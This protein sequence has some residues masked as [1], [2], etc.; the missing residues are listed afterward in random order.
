MLHSFSCCTLF[1][2]HFGQVA[3]FPW[4]TFCNIV[5]S[6]CNFVALH[7]L[8][9]ALFSCRPRLMLHLNFFVF[10]FFHTALFSCYHF[11]LFVLRLFGVALFSL[12]HFPLFF[13][14]RFFA[15]MLHCF[16]VVPFPFCILF[17]A[18][19]FLCIALFYVALNFYTFNFFDLHSSSVPLLA[20]CTFFPDALCSCCTVSRVIARTSTNIYDGE[21]YNIN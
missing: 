14:L 16:H 8:H 10:Y 13:M 5:V 21:L 6:Y 19:L 1:V 11:T 15:F 12:L 20:C 4:C 3:L 7:F 9:V 18:A 2:L 17:H